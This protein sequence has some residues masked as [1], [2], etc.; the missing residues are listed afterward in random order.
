[1][2]AEPPVKFPRCDTIFKLQV[3]RVDFHAGEIRTICIRQREEDLSNECLRPVDAD[4]RHSAG[5]SPPSTVTAG[6]T[7]RQHL[8]NQRRKLQWSTNRH[9]ACSCRYILYCNPLEQSRQLDPL[10][11]PLLDR[12]QASKG[13]DLFLQVCWRGTRRR[14][15]GVVGQVGVREGYED[16]GCIGERRGRYKRREGVGDSDGLVEVEDQMCDARMSVRHS[17]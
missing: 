7:P 11:A 4:N 9:A 17:F 5:I 10:D 14:M 16:V 3:I 12:L 13:G 2:R 6:R 8:R 1:M 15:R